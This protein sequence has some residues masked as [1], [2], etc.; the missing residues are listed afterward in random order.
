M[1]RLH[2]M[3]TSWSSV[4][5][6]RSPPWVNWICTLATS[7]IFCACKVGPDYHRPAPLGTNTVPATYSEAAQTNVGDW[8]AARPGASL[9]RGSWW[10]VFDDSELDQLELQAA[11]NNQQLA[12]ALARFDQAR[13]Q[14]GISRAQL[15]PQVE[16]D[17]SYNR[18][19]T[20]VNEPQNGRRAGLEHTYSTFT[21]PLQAGW[22]I[23]LWGRV[24]RQ[25]DAARAGAYAGADDLE[26][27]KL[28]IPAELA[29]DYF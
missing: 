13:A 15:F 4:P 25:V 17:P 22:E 21:L 14:I 27:T 10:R 7:L 29:A 20:S 16:T 26:S 1:T 8:K 19:R 24:R 6:R 18:Q 9:P 5:A 23:D 11:A 2:F 12:G 3:A 28:A